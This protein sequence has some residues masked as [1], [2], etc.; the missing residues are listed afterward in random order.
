MK[1]VC[2]ECDAVLS[3]YNPGKLCFPCQEKR[4]AWSAIRDAEFIDP[5]GYA[6]ILGLESEES[7]KRLA[8]DDK[9]APRVPA[10]KK[11]LWRKDVVIDWMKREGQ[12]LN[13]DLRM[14]IRGIAS[15]LRICRNDPII[16]LSLSDKIGGKIYG[17]ESVLG[18]TASGHVEPIELVKIDR[19][20]ALNILKKLQEEEFPYL[21]GVTDWGDLTYDRITEDLITRL[22]A[23]F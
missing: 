13:K 10:I 18:T 6:D 17:S 9:L 20:V 3:Q 23:Y 11:W 8:R 22:E 19:A 7:V 21:I 2:Y 14:A 15:N 4:L 12:V 1:R 16:F 5:R